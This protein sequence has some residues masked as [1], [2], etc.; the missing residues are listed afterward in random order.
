MTTASV[1]V[2]IPQ[3]LY[4][5]LEQ[6]AVRLQKPV[7][8]LLVETLQAALPAADEIPDH[9]KA[10]VAALD[11]LDRVRLR[12]I[13]ESEMGLKDQQSLEQILDWQGIRPLTNEETSQLAALRTEYGR[14]L[15]RK[16]RAFALLAERGQPIPLE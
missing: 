11:R 12:E 16:A 14:I 10:E 5:R 6:T 15:L 13:A 3:A 2:K 4:H 8:K 9:I 7:E 1:A